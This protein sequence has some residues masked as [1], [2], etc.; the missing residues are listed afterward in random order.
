MKKNR[1]GAWPPATPND[2]TV[3]DNYANDIWQ[4]T[5]SKNSNTISAY[6]ILIVFFLPSLESIQIRRGI[7][8]RKEFR[9]KMYLRCLTIIFK[10]PKMKYRYQSVVL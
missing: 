7:T 10:Y 1:R 8:I 3:M 2:A 5:F 4:Q 9:V 6:P